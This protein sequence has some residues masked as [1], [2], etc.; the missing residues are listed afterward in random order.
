[1]L[2]RDYFLRMIEEFCAAISRFLVKKEDDLERDKDLKDLYRQY[3]GDYND[4]RNLSLSEAIAYANEQWKEG[5]R[6]DKLNMLAELL[7][8]EA[9]FKANPLGQMLLEKAYSLFDYVEENGSTFS[10]NRRQRMEKIR[11]ELI[12]RT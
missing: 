1:M 11:Q 5:E 7:Y 3:V 4:L 6:M 12:K 2:Q 8:A 9:C 10:I